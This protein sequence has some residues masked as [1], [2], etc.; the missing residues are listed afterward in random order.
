MSKWKKEHSIEKSLSDKKHKSLTM[1][2][3]G[4]LEAWKYPSILRHVNIIITQHALTYFLNDLGKKIFE[5]Q[6]TKPSN[7]LAPAIFPEFHCVALSTFTFYTF[8]PTTFFK[9]VY[10][11]K[12][13]ANQQRLTSVSTPWLSNMHSTDKLYL[14]QQG[15]CIDQESWNDPPSDVNVG[16]LFHAFHL[17][18]FRPFETRP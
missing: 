8:H 11:A 4:A 3:N 15:F 18:Y 2:R 5:Y 7:K 1:R 12:K 9:R 13:S 6:E 17:C 10:T 16:I 14:R